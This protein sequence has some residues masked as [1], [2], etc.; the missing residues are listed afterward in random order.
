MKSCVAVLLKTVR[1][2]SVDIWEDAFQL[3]GWGYE[4]CRLTSAW[5]WLPG[6]WLQ[7]VLYRR[8]SLW[9]RFRV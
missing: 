3:W 4:G 9:S 7:D 2:L 5:D 8:A 6:F 1:L